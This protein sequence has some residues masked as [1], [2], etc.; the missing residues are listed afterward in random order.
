MRKQFLHLALVL[1]AFTLV[2][3]ACGPQPTAV[4]AAAPTAVPAP[5]QAPAATTAPTAVG[6]Q[7]PDIQSGKFNV[8]VV[9]IGFHAD[10]GW[11]Q[12]H[13]EGAQW[14][15]KQDPTINVQ[16]V[17]LVNPGPDSETVMRSLAR[18]GFDLIIGTRSTGCT[19]LAFSPMAQTMATYSARWKT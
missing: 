7:I 5:T 17:E 4:P 9:L 12:A 6:F 10:G 19:S 11:S 13:T 14:M 1:A 8:A 2:M 3:A 18:K 15:A 16:Y